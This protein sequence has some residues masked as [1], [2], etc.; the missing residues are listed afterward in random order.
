VPQLKPAESRILAEPLHRRRGSGCGDCQNLVLGW[1]PEA[2]CYTPRRIP[3]QSGNDTPETRD[4]RHRLPHPQLGAMLR[5]GDART[6]WA[7]DGAADFW[8]AGPAGAP[9]GVRRK[10]E[11]EVGTD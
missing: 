5:T 10:R 1:N 7:R 9:R 2:D 6:V 11:R 4:D 8:C 3:R